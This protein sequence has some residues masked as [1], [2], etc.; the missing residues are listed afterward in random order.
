MKLRNSRC[1]P[2]YVLRES[3][4]FGRLHVHELVSLE[5]RLSDVKLVFATFE[6]EGVRCRD[7]VLRQLLNTRSPL[8]PTS[9]GRKAF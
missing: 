4:A 2:L 5:R 8:A 6:I 1:N 7:Y 3:R 9:K